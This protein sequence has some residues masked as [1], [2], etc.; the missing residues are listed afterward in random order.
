MHGA[1]DGR[2]KWRERVHGAPRFSRPS[3]G[4]KLERARSG[5][6]LVDGLQRTPGL[7][8]RAEGHG[9]LG[10]CVE[11]GW[12]LPR[13]PQYKGTKA[14][15]RSVWDRVCLV[16][17]LRR[18]CGGRIR[19]AARTLQQSIEARPSVVV[20]VVVVVVVDIS[21]PGSSLR[22]DIVKAEHPRLVCCE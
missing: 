22:L 11:N 2:M 13:R 10:T 6:A 1:P 17:G 14:Q 15:A 21:P 8:W 12:T 20:V 7:A 16:W 9:E 5:A 18:P 3:A 19:Q 4:N